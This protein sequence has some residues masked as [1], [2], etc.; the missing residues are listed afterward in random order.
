MTF[1]VDSVQIGPVKDGRQMVTLPS[2][3]KGAYM[4][5]EASVEQVDQYMANRKEV[6]KQAGVK[7]AL[8][9]GIATVVGAACAA[10]SKIDGKLLEKSV[11]GAACGVLVGM[12]GAL[13]FMEQAQN[14]IQK[15]NDQFIAQNSK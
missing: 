7:E 4:Q 2:V 13:G 3:N 9:F 1:M 5:C 12:I 11:L 6:E 15:L 10:V 14:K 8:S